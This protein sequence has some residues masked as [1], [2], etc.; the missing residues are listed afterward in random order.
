MK[1]WEGQGKTTNLSQIPPIY[2]STF[3]NSIS[4]EFSPTKGLNQS[5]GISP[6]KL[7]TKAKLE[8]KESELGHILDRHSELT[9]TLNL[10]STQ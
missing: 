9:D 7:G 10:E 8:E 2:E 3:A 1:E 4:F 6:E 5:Q